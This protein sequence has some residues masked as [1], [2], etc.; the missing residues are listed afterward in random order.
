MRKFGRAKSHW[1]LSA[2][3]KFWLDKIWKKWSWYGIIDCI[4]TTSSPR[5]LMSSLSYYPRWRHSH[6]HS[7]IRHNDV[8]KSKLWR[9]YLHDVMIL[10]LPSVWIYPEY[11]KV[12]LSRR[13]SNLQDD[14]RISEDNR[15]LDSNYLYMYILPR[16]H[17]KSYLMTFWFYQ[18]DRRSKN[19]FDQISRLLSSI[20]SENVG[21]V[22][23]K[24]NCWSKKRFLSQIFEFLT[25]WFSTDGRHKLLRI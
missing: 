19:F 12:F 4:H 13:C 20:F 18:E 1:V 15:W 16:S 3:V 7:S 2:L 22:L 10:I 24:N 25:L 23:N 21:I 5:L 17:K 9:H 14:H 8:M 11:I 6:V